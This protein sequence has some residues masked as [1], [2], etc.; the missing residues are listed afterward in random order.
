MALQESYPQPTEG[1]EFKELSPAL[2]QLTGGD[3][4]GLEGELRLAL[5]EIAHLRNE[6]QE[7]QQQ[8]R[9]TQL[10]GGG[11][12][13]NLLA[14]LA[15]ELRQPL[16]SII[17]YTDFLLGESVGILGTLQRKFLERIRIA[18]QRMMAILDDYTPAIDLQGGQMQL[19][20][21]A[22]SLSEVL[23]NALAEVRELQ[24]ARQIELQSDLPAELSPGFGRPR[25]P[26]T[27]SGQTAPKRPQSLP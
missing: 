25:R 9:R 8:L 5:E 20:V 15:T 1:E 22:V 10:E 7:T 19:S 21:E 26:R 12:G 6:L 23:E 11:E 27:D 24:N 3:A 13:V 14:N 4:G 17:G 16:A 2:P 18:T